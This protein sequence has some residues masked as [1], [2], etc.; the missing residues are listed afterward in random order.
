MVALLRFVVSALGYLDLYL[1]SVLGKRVL[2]LRISAF[3]LLLY[4]LMDLLVVS[5]SVGSCLYLVPQ[6]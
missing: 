2:Y 5:C 4:F 6:C 3:F 1:R